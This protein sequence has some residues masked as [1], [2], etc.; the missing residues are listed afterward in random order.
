M[1]DDLD[2]DD[3]LIAEGVA[4]SVWKVHDDNHGWL[5]LK[6]AST[7]AKL[8]PHDI[9]KESRLLQKLNQHNIISLISTYY[10][11]EEFTMN[12]WMPF[13]SYSLEQ[14]LQSPRFSPHI[15][16]GSVKWDQEQGFM[17]LS[18]SLF[19]QTLSAV[20]FIHSQGF[21]HRDIKPANILIAENGCVKIID[22]GVAFAGDGDSQDLWPESPSR[23]YFEVCTGPYRPPELLFGAR[24]YDAPSIDSWCLGAVFA[25]F[26]TQLIVDDDD[27][28]QEETTSNQ[29]FHIPSKLTNENP[30]RFKWIRNSLF[31]GTR[32]E[33][34][35]AWSIFKIMGT[36]TE[37]TWPEFKKL[38]DAQRVE[39]NIVPP[40]DL[41]SLLPNLPS[42]AD[43]F[44]I[45]QSLLRYP[46]SGRLT[47]REAMAQAWFKGDVLVPAGFPDSESV[48]QLVTEWSGMNLGQL[49]V[50]ALGR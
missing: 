2:E 27:G 37:D 16:L 34:G 29:P 20:A 12:L 21:A 17:T 38:P 25:E 14:L 46:P 39:F 7:R 24:Q 19:F 33:I 4:S 13:I 1:R 10:D 15:F 5:A 11:P 23:M 47:P 45:L 18:K 30:G 40:V 22:F 50:W 36:P 26:F 3:E 8:E 6:S 32:G 48:R 35:L 9:V 44:S 49:L 41:K 31:N 28:E 43:P 42:S